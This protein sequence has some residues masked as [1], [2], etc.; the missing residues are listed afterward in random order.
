MWFV[1][2]QVSRPGFWMRGM[3]FPIDLVWIGP[4]R[5]VLGHL[6]LPPC[7]EAP[8]PISLPAQP[9]AYVLEVGAGQF[10]GRVGDRVE[11][12]CAASA[13]P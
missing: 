8:C 5:E 7:R 10:S 11:W 3:R 2:P 6:T 13:S 9:V 12:Q 4:R 1:L